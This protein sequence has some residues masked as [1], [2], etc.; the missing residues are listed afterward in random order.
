[1]QNKGSLDGLIYLIPF[2]KW[3]IFI[4]TALLLWT[5]IYFFFP[6]TGD[7]TNSYLLS[8]IS[9]MFLKIFLDYICGESIKIYYIYNIG[10]YE[11]KKRKDIIK[12]SFIILLLILLWFNSSPNYYL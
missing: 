3:L 12:L 6:N 4:Y 9:L 5:S 2:K 10:K 7:P 8:I 1:M 11:Y